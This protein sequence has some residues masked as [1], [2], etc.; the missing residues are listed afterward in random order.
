M[1]VLLRALRSVAGGT[2]GRAFSGGRLRRARQQVRRVT[3]TVLGPVIAAMSLVPVPAAAAA[4]AVTVGA[5]AVATAAP[6]KA[7]VSLPVL[8]VQ[9]NGE[10]SAPEA[11]LLTSA[12]YTVTQ[13]TTTALQSMSKPTFQGYAAVVIGDPSS[14]GACP[15]GWT[16]AALTSALGT[17][18]EGWVT[19]NVAV[20]GTNAGLAV[21]LASSGNTAAQTLI[22]DAAGYAA[23]QPGTTV[24]RTGLY[25]SL[26]C[27]YSAAVQGT[28]VPVLDGIY[29]D[30]AATQTI[31]AAGH[32]T[33]NGSLSCA[34]SGTVNK[35]EA[36]AAGTFSGFTSSSLA[37]GA[38]GWPSPACPVQEGF[39]SWPAMFTPIA[40]DAASTTGNFTASDGVAG[41]PYILLGSPVSAA[42]TGLA[43]STGGEVPAGTTSGGTSNPVADGVSQSLAAGSVNTETG[44][45]TQSVAD[46]SVPTFGPELS[47]SRTYDSGTAQ[48][49]TKTGTASAM[50]AGWTDNWASS[51]TT[52]RPVEGD[53]YTLD[54]LRGNLN[55]GGYPGSQVM[56]NP[57]G[58]AVSGGN[59]YM[60]DSTGNR[61][62]EVAHSTGTQWGQSMT[63]GDTYVVAGSGSSA[64]GALNHPQGIAFDSAGDM[65]I[66]DTWDSRIEEIPATSKTQWGVTM[67]ANQMYTVAGSASDANGYTGD[68]GAPAS[69]LLHAPG[70]IAFDSA[71]DMYIADG[72]NNRVQEIFVTGGST[73][74]ITMTAGD[75]YTVAGN[76]S[77]T[78]GIA[79]NG[80][81]SKNAYLSTPTSV[82]TDTAGDVYIS[83]SGN[84]RVQE[85][86]KAAGA[87]WGVST[88]AASDIYTIAGS[89]T[90]TAGFSGDTTWRRPQ[91]C[92][93]RRRTWPGPGRTCTSRTRCNNV[94]REVAGTAHTQWGS[95]SMT[96]NDI[97]TIAGT[98]STG[99]TGDGGAAT[100][101][102]LND[103]L[104]LAL[105]TSGNLYIADASNNCDPRGDHRRHHL[106]LCRQRVHR[107]QHRQRRPRDAGRAEQPAAGGVRRQRRHLHRR[108]RQQPD[109]GDRR[110]HPHPV[111]HRDDRRR[112]VHRRRAGHRPDRQP[113]RRRA[114]HLLQPERPV[115]H[116]RRPGRQPVHRR[117]RQQPHPGSPRR[118]R[119][120]VGPV[121]DRRRHLHRRR[122]RHRRRRLHR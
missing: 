106:Q 48:Q 94:V 55:V 29:T 79:G 62:L 11:A 28:P 18:W 31:G 107:G 32:V 4:A 39:D 66:A 43:P 115:E 49:Q 5:A 12:G 112:R 17:N 116:R 96:A 27:A 76:A 57:A 33:V 110:L 51:L 88:M 2:F 23:A 14:S 71:G 50:G 58:V 25:L 67:T 63:G 24:T 91:R 8:V 119:H 89:A 121:H 26:D 47:F 113:D 52:A 73:W 111:G 85:M 117:H 1:M 82:S 68:G 122:Q 6:A 90:G 42:T 80:G 69:A 86:A 114:G 120:P 10:S 84:N 41:Q 77:G 22:T 103:P 65:Y 36:A 75:I 99:H 61:V 56:G 87:Q 72:G 15:S 13:V 46:V 102:T 35:W 105:D 74:G 81:A 98:G 92:W 16:S 93:T 104:Q 97:Y 44:D 20:L 109:P 7:A 21:S 19:G 9:V 95:T 34:D 53:I 100:S 45:L 70:G 3:A 118:H 64:G 59:V 38:P 83:D 54:G 60:A 30:T 101:A 40:Y 78:A 108:R 37:A